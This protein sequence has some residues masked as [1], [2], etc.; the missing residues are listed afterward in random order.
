[1]LLLEAGPDYPQFEHLPDTAA[2]HP[3]TP[4][5]ADAADNAAE[6]GSFGGSKQPVMSLQFPL[7]CDVNSIEFIVVLFFPGAY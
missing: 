2:G 6:L 4:I 1:M 7:A 3:I 5:A